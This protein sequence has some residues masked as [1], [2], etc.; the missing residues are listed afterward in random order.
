MST[1]PPPTGP[2]STVR[3][4]GLAVTVG[5]Y[6][7]ARLGLLVVVA[8]LLAAAGV[9]FVIAVLVGLIVALPLSMVLFRGLRGR[10]DEALNDARQRRSAERDALRARLRGGGPAPDASG[11]GSDE[12]AERQPDARED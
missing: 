1:P 11:A 10:M 12:P 3:Q 7:L 8:A 4:P 2:S 5:L 9:P 6:A